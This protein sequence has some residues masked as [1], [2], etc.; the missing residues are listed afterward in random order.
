M[1][2]KVWIFNPRAVRHKILANEKVEVKQRCDRFIETELKPNNIKPFNPKN[3]KESQLVDIYCKW[4]GNKI[5]FIARYKDLRPQAIALE[6]EDKFARLVYGGE[7]QCYLDYMRHTGEWW[8]ITY[9]V[10]NSFSKCLQGI[11]ELPYFNL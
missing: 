1:P 6:Y 9:Q 7:K 3:K 2:K 4:Y 5:I 11:K 8:D 10:G